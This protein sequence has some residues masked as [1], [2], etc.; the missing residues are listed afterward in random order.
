MNPIDLLTLVLI[1]VALIL[2][3]R[4][5][6]IPQISGLLGAIGGGIVAILL[7]PTFADPLAAVDPTYRPF[8]VLAGLVLAVGIGE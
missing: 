6:A 5:G 3:W 7:L 8:V 1:V 2:G 4:S